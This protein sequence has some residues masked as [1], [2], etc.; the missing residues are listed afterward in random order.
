MQHFASLIEQLQRTVYPDRKVLHLVEYMHTTAEQDI[1]WMLSLLSG[2]RPKRMTT[3]SRLKEWAISVTEIPVWLFEESL[4]MSGD[5]AE[6]ISLLIDFREEASGKHLHQWM[7]VYA[8]VLKENETVKEQFVKN[9]WK[10]LNVAEKY[11]FNKLIT[12][13]FRTTVS[14]QILAKALAAVAKM[15]ET[16]VLYKLKSKW[17]PSDLGLKEL[18]LSHA[19]DAIAA[20]PFPF[21]KG[22]S[23]PG[24]ITKL[25]DPT[26]WNAELHLPG[27][28]AQ[29]VKRNG[30][31]NIWSTK[32]DLITD[33]FPEMQE[34]V[35][36]LPDGTVL[37][38][39]LVAFRE[40]ILSGIDLEQKRL[41]RKN[42]TS[43][44]LE[45]S[46]FVFFAYDL[47]ESDSVDIREKTLFDRRIILLELLK[48]Y[49]HYKVVL[50]ELVAFSNWEILISKHQKA[51]EQ[52]VSGFILK[53]LNSSYR[54]GQQA[55]DW[56]KWKVK[57]FRVYAVLLYVS[58]GG[59]TVPYSEFTFGV[60]NGSDV[61]AIG[62]TA[63]RLTGEDNS[64]VHDF[65]NEH[66]LEK[67]GPVR[68]ITPELV[69]EIEFD[70]VMLSTRHKSGLVL[71]GLR[72][73]RWMKNVS[74]DKAVTLSRLKNRLEQ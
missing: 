23:V 49:K 51:R 12:G 11:V 34:N 25:G 38:G 1:L 17:H 36:G 33:R 7:D 15:P 16:E 10:E 42:L 18:I 31:L 66:I 20:K 63:N 3:S 57:P 69:F 73:N 9:A 50:S 41:G 24:E 30:K 55:D 43:A 44:T 56:W 19:E 46:P 26:E 14:F 39:Q 53:R 67:F 21:L 47:L 29:I 45:A 65:I 5:L 32:G 27:I 48:V 2:N 40:H 68:S 74:Q 28:R 61:V 37:E 52:R 70:Q 59:K 71:K 58:G 6:T 54:N 60:R 8:K 4:I 72:M 13:S 62:K 35:E 64:M 22:N